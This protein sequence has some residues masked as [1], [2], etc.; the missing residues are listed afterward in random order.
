MCYVKRASY[1]KTARLGSNLVGRGEIM[2]SDALLLTGIADDGGVV[3]ESESAYGM[4]D[5]A[6]CAHS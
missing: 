5:C 4:F 2:M 1:D 3:E 6:N